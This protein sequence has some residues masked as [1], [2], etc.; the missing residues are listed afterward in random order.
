MQ[1][2]SETLQRTSGHSDLLTVEPSDFSTSQPSAAAQ[3]VSSLCCGVLPRGRQQGAPRAAILPS[4]HPECVMSRY[5]SEHS[6]GDVPCGCVSCPGMS[7]PLIWNPTQS[8]SLSGVRDGTA[9]P[10]LVLWPFSLPTSHAL[11]Q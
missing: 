8:C 5:D 3:Q 7:T 2:V 4:H 9:F 1:C 10:E 6:C 11:G